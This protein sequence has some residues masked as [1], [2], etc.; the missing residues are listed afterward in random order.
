M[1]KQIRSFTVDKKICDSIVKLF[2][3]YKV[4][5]S[6]SS[7]VDG[8]LK[9]LL[10]LLEDCEAIIESHGRF[11]EYEGMMA[12]MAERV[13]YREDRISHDQ[14]VNLLLTILDDLKEEIEARKMNYSVELYKFA[15][16]DGFKMSKDKKYLF[17]KTTG[18]KFTIFK[19][20]E[21][22]LHIDPKPDMVTNE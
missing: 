22:L 3:K 11:K 16:L 2:K 18:R 12:V 19:T 9:E 1:A 7:Y 14:N 10:S 5:I 4:E 8:C 15:I 21:G 17:D 20:K 13:V 6:L